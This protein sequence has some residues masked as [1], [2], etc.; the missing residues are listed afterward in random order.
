VNEVDHRLPIVLGKPHSRGSDTPLLALNLTH[1]SGHDYIVLYKENLPQSRRSKRRK[2]KRAETPNFPKK[3]AK[4]A[5]VLS[6][7]NE[8]FFDFFD[9][10][11]KKFCGA[12]LVLAGY[13]HSI[14]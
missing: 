10:A 7:S 11:V 8:N 12:S 4:T 6:N 13:F 14:S 2:E 1:N 9:F 5:Q 3:M